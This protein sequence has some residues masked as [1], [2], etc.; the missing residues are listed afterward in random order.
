MVFKPTDTASQIAADIAKAVN[1]VDSFVTASAGR[2]RVSFLGA[3]SGNFS[4]LTAPAGRRA[5][6][7]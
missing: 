5:A 4:T 2:N 1:G 3:S 7:Q 6:T